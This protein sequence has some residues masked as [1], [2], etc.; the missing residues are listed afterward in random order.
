MD[1]GT[2]KRKG[3]DLDYGLI[4]TVPFYDQLLNSTSL[5]LKMNEEAVDFP[6]WKVT[7]GE[8]NLFAFRA[9]PMVSTIS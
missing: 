7:V 3:I 8:A 1:V 4:W 5:E 6:N 9:S 2:L